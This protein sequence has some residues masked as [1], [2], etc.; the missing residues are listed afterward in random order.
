VL[1]SPPLPLP[2]QVNDITHDY[3]VLTL[4]QCAGGEG[5]NLEDGS[6]VSFDEVQGTFEKIN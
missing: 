1:P 6:L 4:G 5:G 2:P 3:T